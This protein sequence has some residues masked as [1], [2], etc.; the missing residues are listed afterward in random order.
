MTS[1]ND[2][3][4]N[5]SPS[6][7]DKSLDIDIASKGSPPDGDDTGDELSPKG[8]APTFCRLNP[9][10]IPPASLLELVND[11]LLTVPGSARVTSDNGLLM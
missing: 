1:V 4:K 3:T 10:P 6:S 8:E 9:E 7:C 11:W 2:Q 5:T